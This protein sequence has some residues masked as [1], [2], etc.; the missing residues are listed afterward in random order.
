MFCLLFLL[1][2]KG[3]AAGLR[4]K[5]V[6][7]I[8]VFHFQ[9]LIRLLKNDFVDFFLLFWSISFFDWVA[10]ESESDQGNL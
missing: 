1:L 4:L 7:G 5:H 9:A 6:N 10:I 8:F 2:E 3:F